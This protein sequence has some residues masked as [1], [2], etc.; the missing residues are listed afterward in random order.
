MPNIWDY[1]DRSGTGTGGPTIPDG[2]PLYIVNN[3]N[4]DTTLAIGNLVYFSTAVEE[5]VIKLINN[6]N[7]NFA[8]G[9]V[10]EKLTDTTCKVLHYGISLNNYANILLG[11]KVYLGSNGL[12]TSTLPNNGYIQVLGTTMYSNIL[13]FNPITTKIKR[14][15]F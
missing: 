14:Y 4:C 13:F 7:V 6:R 9:I 3:Y 10:E 8:I 12:P 5:S 11:K 15:P 2:S 1:F